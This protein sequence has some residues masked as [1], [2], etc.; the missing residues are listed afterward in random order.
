VSAKRMAAVN[1]N[2]QAMKSRK[3]SFRLESPK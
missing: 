2:L 1:A 3:R